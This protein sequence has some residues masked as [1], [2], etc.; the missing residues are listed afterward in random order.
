[1]HSMNVCGWGRGEHN[2]EMKLA[3]LVCQWAIPVNEDTPPW[4]IIMA[5]FRDFLRF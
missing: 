1:M 4:K 2:S 5:V 3:H